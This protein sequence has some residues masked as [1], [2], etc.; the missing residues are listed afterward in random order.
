MKNFPIYLTAILCFLFTDC[1]NAEEGEQDINYA[2]YNQKVIDYLQRKY[3]VKVETVFSLTF[4]QK[5]SK[6]D[7]QSFEEYYKFISDL[8]RTPLRLKEKVLSAP[9]KSPGVQTSAFHKNLCYEMDDIALTVYY[10]VDSNGYV[11]DEPH[12]YAGLWNEGWS[13]RNDNLWYQVDNYNSDCSASGDK[14]WVNAVRADYTTLHYTKKVY[15]IVDGVGVWVPDIQYGYSAKH[16][17][18]I[19]ATGI[20]NVTNNQ[21]EFSIHYAG[22]GSW[23]R[24]LEFGVIK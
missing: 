14:I 1:N 17:I 13:K 21:G 2:E 10:D 8:K 15:K 19:T 22:E 7:V 20:I 18:K 9:M 16:T 12:I 4:K 23:S 6:E 24:D 11:A 5:L 3:D